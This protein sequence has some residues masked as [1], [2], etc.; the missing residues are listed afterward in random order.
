MAPL[1]NIAVIVIAYATPDV[2]GMAVLK[3]VV[4]LCPGGTGH[5]PE[6]HGTPVEGIT[7]PLT[8]TA[9]K[10]TEPEFS[11]VIA[12]RPV[13]EPLGTAICALTCIWLVVWAL[14]AVVLK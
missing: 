14:V 3:L 1:A 12:I 2:T 9:F 8:N 4:A 13:P 7:V 6:A 10:A 11:T 5:V